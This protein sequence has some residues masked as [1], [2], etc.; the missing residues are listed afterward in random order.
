MSD[1]TTVTTLVLSGAVFQI[2][3]AI[4]FLIGGV[5]SSIGTAIGFLLG[6]INNPLDLIWVFIPGIPLIVFSILGFLFGYSWLRWRHTPAQY[7]Q[8]LI[9][10]G[11]IALIFTGFIPGLLVLIGGAIIPEETAKQR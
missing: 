5:G 1:E 4:F 9:M 3:I 8:K 2:I 11:I 6:G 7:K 10:T